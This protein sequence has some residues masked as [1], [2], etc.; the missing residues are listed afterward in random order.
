MTREKEIWVIAKT[1]NRNKLEWECGDEGRDFDLRDWRWR[2]L[3]RHR[4]LH[5]RRRRRLFKPHIISSSSSSSLS[6]S[7]SSS[8]LL[9]LLFDLRV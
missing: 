4:R 6:L 3:L 1:E 7:S 9:L 8:S 2:R 5:R